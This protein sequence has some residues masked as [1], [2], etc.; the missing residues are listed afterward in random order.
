MLRFVC[1]WCKT[2]KQPGESWVMGWAVENVAPTAQRREVQL[3]QGWNYDR[4]VHPLA[5]HFCSPEHAQHYLDA[6]FGEVPAAGEEVI[7]TRAVLT[8]AKR[9]P[10]PAATSGTRRKP[11]RAAK[12]KRRRA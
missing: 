12:A 11:A 9:R 8:S 3:A 2:E 6:L 10:A 7:E 4:A 5:V 1:D